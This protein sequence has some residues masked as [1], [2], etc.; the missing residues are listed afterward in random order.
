LSLYP[1]QEGILTHDIKE[2]VLVFI[3]GDKNTLENT[4]QRGTQGKN[5]NLENKSENQSSNEKSSD[6]LGKSID[7]L[8]KG[9]FGK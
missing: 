9:I 4:P 2:G 8:F 1:I 5:E 7:N 3:V 6:N